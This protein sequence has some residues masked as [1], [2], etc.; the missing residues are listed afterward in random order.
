MGNEPEIVK[1]LREEERCRKIQVKSTSSSEYIRKSDDS[2]P[3]SSHDTTMLFEVDRKQFKNLSPENIEEIYRS[4]FH[5]FPLAILVLDT[6]KRIILWN[7]YTETLLGKTYEELYLQSISTLH[8]PDE[9]RYIESTIHQQPCLQYQIETKLQMKNNESLEVAVSHHILKNFEGGNLGF[10]Y[11]IQN[12]SKQKQAEHQLNSLFDYADDAIYVVDK[13]G[14]FLMVNNEF[15]SELGCP[16]EKV[17]GKTFHDFH[18]SEETKVFAQKLTWVF[19]QGRPLKDISCEDGKWFFRTINPIKESPLS[20]TNAVLVIS[21][22][23]TES[24]TKEDAS[25]ENEKKY[26]T[27]FD[28]FPQMIFLLDTQGKILE[29]NKQIAA[30]LGYQPSELVE[31]NFLSLPF[32]TKESKKV[33]KKHFSKK[34]LNK[35]ISPFEIDLYTKPG[36]K[37]IGVVQLQSLRNEQGDILNDLVIIS[38]KTQQKQG[39]EIKQIKDQALTLTST[40]ITL[41]SLQGNVT[42]ANNA[43]LRLWG[44]SNS[45]EAIGKTIEQLCEMKIKFME[46]MNV[47]LNT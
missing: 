41:I 15:L 38:D 34:K 5:S 30:W 7:R 11:I 32:F 21:K 17:L 27:V 13:N 47:L 46:V 39:E 40:P 16:R 28:F 23:I 33:I 3:H 36:E 6:Q 43:F 9:W 31:K 20:R 10:L 44:Y 12:I 42:Y 45:K 4:V 8:S 1:I 22:D 14:Q 24:I 29:V 18:S 2:L 35:T 26:R 25:K 37:Q 19:N